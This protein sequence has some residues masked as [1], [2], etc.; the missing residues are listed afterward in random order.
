MPAAEASPSQRWFD[1]YCRNL[2]LQFAGRSCAGAACL[3]LAFLLLQSTPLPFL[4]FL[5]GSFAILAVCLIGSWLLHRP[6]YC[7]QKLYRQDSAFAE[8]LHSSLQFRENPPASQTT[9]IFL[10]RFEKQ[11]LERLEG[12]ETHRLLPP[13]RT[14]V[15]V[16]VSLQVVVWIGG[17]WLPQYLVNQ[18]STAAE[19]LQIPHS[20]RILYPA[21]L[22]RDSEVFSTLPNELQIPAGSR[23]EIFL[24]QGLPDGDQSA[25][26]PIQGEPQPLQWV[27]QQQRW[28]SALTPL[29]TGTLFLEWRQQSVAVEV[30]PDLSPTVMVL[31]PPDKY[32]FDL[33]QLQVELEAKDDYGLRQILLRYRNEATGI[34]EREIIQ[35]FEGD[36]KSYQESYL[37]ELSATPLRA[38]DNVTAWIEV[39]DSD[40]F[41]G[42][43]V[44]RSE[45]FRFE[46]RSQREFHEYI[47]SLFRKVDRELRD[48]LSVLDR[49]LIVETTDQEN[50]IEELLNFLQEEANYDRLLSDGLRGFIGEL[51]FQLRFY[52]RKREELAVPP[53]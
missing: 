8:A 46:V 33:S 50:L 16:A 36:F 24:E 1:Q 32:I 53:S 26:R 21:Y 28:R 10:E 6:E 13:W 49:Q 15:G 20:Y 41:Q 45:E 34:I 51:R 25:Y 17:W 2:R 27:P 42:P 40:T 44:T 9:N 19:A 38:G 47:L 4:N 11:L 43:N 35:S 14:L 3:L 12:E 29:K 30:I 22:K 23:L 39:S 52:Q 5:L 31:W 18:G 48:L 7:L 37:W